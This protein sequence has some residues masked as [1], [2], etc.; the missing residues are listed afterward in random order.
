MLLA[1][2]DLDSVSPD[3]IKSFLIVAGWLVTMGGAVYGGARWAKRGTKDSPIAVEQPLNVQKHDGTVRK[4]EL[5]EVKTSV[6][7][8]ETSITSLAD[9]INGQFAAMT[10]AGQDRAA[11]IT[12]SIDEEVGALQT[13]IGQ[14]ADALHEK[15]NAAVVESAR[16]GAEIDGLKAG[17]FRHN[18]E[19]NRIQEHIAHLLTR[20]VCAHR[21]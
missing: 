1:A 2:S 3:F 10:K 6:T 12:Q 13:K 5:S 8:L 19:I 16:H 20:P 17:E 14:L 7:K 21:K 9:Q 18:G 4:S 11:A 15:I